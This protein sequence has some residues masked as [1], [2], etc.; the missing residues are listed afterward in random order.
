MY[1]YYK[2]ACCARG[3]IL[4]VKNYTSGKYIDCVT[5]EVTFIR[6]SRKMTR[7]IRFKSLEFNG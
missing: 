5:R 6:Y 2:I 4:I 3:W 1:A 7:S